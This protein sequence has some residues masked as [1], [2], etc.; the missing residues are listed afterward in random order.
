MAVLNIGEEKLVRI[1]DLPMSDGHAFVGR[2]KSN[3]GESLK[4]THSTEVTVQSA[5]S[6]HV[7]NMTWEADGKTQ[8]APVVVRSF[9]AGEIVCQLVIEEKRSS[10]RLRCDVDLFITPIGPDAVGEVAARLM[11]RI[12]TGPVVESQVESLMRVEQQE[13]SVGAE[14]TLIRILLE[15]LLGQMEHMTNVIEGRDTGKE[16]AEVEIADVNDI[17]ATGLSMRD[18]TNLEVGTFIKLRLVFRAVP[19]TTIHCVGVVVRSSERA[20]AGED[21]NTRFEMGVRY[22]HIHEADR[23]RIYNQIFKAQRSQ[24]RDLSMAG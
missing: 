24:L 17:S 23:E 13:D 22:T 10:L 19:K 5:G 9:S 1:P 6:D 16:A 3:Q 15:K 18:A 21:S 4:L 7:Y 11:S 20:D 2:V 14:L 8:M 12:P